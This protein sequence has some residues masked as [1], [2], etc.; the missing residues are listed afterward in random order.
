MNIE[1]HLLV[2]RFDTSRGW[3]SV[4]FSID[5]AHNAIIV[6]TNS[7]G[8]YA[9]LHGVALGMGENP[10]LPKVPTLMGNVPNPFN[11][12]TAISYYLPTSVDSK[13]SIFD[14]N[15]RCLAKFEQG[16]RIG[17]VT[18]L[19]DGVDD[20]GLAVGS[21]VYFVRLEAGKTVSTKSMVLIK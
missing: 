2:Y 19:W 8:I 16:Q 5:P 15:G 9:V 3:Q 4:P 12:R 14:I 13:I 21:G 11:A 7:F 6:I 17:L 10:E 1:E 20:K 18:V